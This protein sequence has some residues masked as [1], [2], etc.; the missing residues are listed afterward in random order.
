MIIESFINAVIQII[1]FS[2]IPFCWWL[3]FARKKY[4]FLASIGLQ[5]SIIENK[6]YYSLY[7]LMVIALLVIPIHIIVHFFVDESLLASERFA[8]LGLA[9]VLPALIYSVFQTGLSEELF[10]RGFLAKRFIARW[11][12][13]KGN[14]LQ[15]LLFG[16]IHGL[17]F[18]STV[19]L[20][21][22]FFIFIATALAGYLMGWMNEKVSKGSIITSWAIH[23][24]A[25]FLA[26]IKM[27]FNL[28]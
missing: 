16:A 6:A 7:F 9:A 8:G 15:S 18:L 17:M 20:V 26:A 14:L 22:V 2:I 23:S 11:E 4:S 5:K 21:G 1:L 25:N 19:Q 27:M 12:F 28:V 13:K 24:I 10:F 3:V